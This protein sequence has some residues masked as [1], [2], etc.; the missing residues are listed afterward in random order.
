[1]SAVL[2]DD[3]VALAGG[4]ALAYR[5]WGEPA[6]T[7]VLLL[8]G[9]PGSR[10]WCPDPEATAAAGVRL[11]TFD[12]PGYGGSDPS[13][14]VDVGDLVGDVEILLDARGIDR[15]GIV[16][17]SG[18]GPF[19]AALAHGLP[20][21]VR[22]LALVNAPGPLEE[23]EGG[24]EALRGRQGATARVAPRDP[25]KAHRAVLRFAEAFLSDPVSYLRF[26]DGPDAD[27]VGDPAVRA[28]LEE[29]IRV[30]W[31]RSVDGYARDL[32]ARWRPWGFRLA[33]VVVPTTVFRGA[34][35][36]HNEADARAFAE[37]IP[38]ARLVVWPDAGHYGIVPRFGEVLAAVT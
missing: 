17:F 33:E 2:V 8:H 32:V 19:A 12:R 7:P 21:R 1:V 36:R 22:A 28:A 4:R 31:S 35:D 29:E 26:Q 14:R 11:V 10:A 3:A 16:G 25:A 18:G 30:A 20:Q 6:G 9:I 37:R 34:H 23:V 24:V 27:V 13:E 38:G 15:V 5:E